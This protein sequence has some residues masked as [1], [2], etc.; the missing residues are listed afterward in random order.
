MESAEAEADPLV[1]RIKIATLAKV[2]PG[3]KRTQFLRHMR[4]KFPE[5]SFTA[6]WL[7]H[8]A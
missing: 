7:D 5:L 2:R 6:R 3:H 4:D 8:A 1:R